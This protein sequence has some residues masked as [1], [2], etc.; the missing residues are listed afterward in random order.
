M[1]CRQAHP[2]SYVLMNSKKIQ[3][4]CPVFIKW[5]IAERKLHEDDYVK[6]YQEKINKSWFWSFHP[7]FPISYTTAECWIKKDIG[8]M[9]FSPHAFSYPSTYLCHVQ[10]VAEQLLAMSR[11][12][13]SV[14]VCGD[15][16]DNVFRNWKFNER[17]HG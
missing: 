9:A 10:E 13:T 16:F 15:D 2:S 1:R 4:H 3:A 8:N 14:F 6:A 12:E 17:K 7:S 5:C 11:R